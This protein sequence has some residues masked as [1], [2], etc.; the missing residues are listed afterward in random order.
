MVRAKTAAWADKL[1]PNKSISILFRSLEK[2]ELDQYR[3][4]SWASCLCVGRV[5]IIEII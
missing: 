2:L 4:D 5:A 3:T 1:D